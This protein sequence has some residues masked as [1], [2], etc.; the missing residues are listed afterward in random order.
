MPKPT[1]MTDSLLSRL[2]RF[3]RREWRRAAA[4]W[5]TRAESAAVLRL[6]AAAAAAGVPAA[7][8]I[9]AWAE[10][11]RGG[12]GTRLEKAARL[13]RQGA[14]ATEA[15]AAVPGLVQDDHAVA[16]AF[17]ERISLVGPV[18]RAA[19]A[20]DDLLDP[21]VRRTFR[22]A[23]GYLTVVLLLF[24]TVA[25]YM[26]LRINPMLLQI[27]ES[28]G[29]VRPAALDRWFWIINGVAGF[30]WIPFAVAAAAAVISFSPVIRRI[31]I[32]PWSRPRRIAAALDLLAVAETG[33][34]PSSQS[35][36]MLAECQVD[37]R[38]AAMLARVPGSGPLGKRLA[39]AGLVAPAEAA[40]MD[41]PDA[42]HA[43]VLHQIAADRRLRSRRRVTAVSEAIVP[44]VIMVMGLLVLLQALTVFS[45]LT[46]I[47]DGQV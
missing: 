37:P 15:V 10:D 5:A 29:S 9:D 3:L 28:F 27:L 42:A 16:L 18:V 1:S 22:A 32:R 11:S 23:V 24:L 13:L 39:A 43:L 12:Q 31:V 14:T 26:A 20:G 41:A 4:T 25:G 19:L 44:A 2:R 46:D 21:T 35:V 33:G 17:G 6:V 47:I 8:M 36:T 45:F 30:L 40:E 34:Q 7:T 38:L